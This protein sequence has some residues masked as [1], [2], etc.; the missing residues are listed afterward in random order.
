MSVF[1]LFFLALR[2]AW[3]RPRSR[4]LL[5][6]RTSPLQALSLQQRLRRRRM[7][8]DDVT[9]SL[10]R[11][12][13]RRRRLKASMFDSKQER[14]IEP[15]RA[16]IVRFRTY[17]RHRHTCARLRTIWKSTT[18][19]IAPSSLSFRKMTVVSQRSIWTRST[20]KTFQTNIRRRQQVWIRKTGKR[21]NLSPAYFV[22]IHPF[23]DRVTVVGICVNGAPI[24]QLLGRARI[25]A[26]SAK[27]SSKAL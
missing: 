24:T 20:T 8:I 23:F 12:C 14:T 4:S 21:A 17:L 19:W 15:A 2:R 13:R 22:I 11:L 9:P 10:Q 18:L 26:S 25:S 5:L 1:L 7:Q 16:P 27:A 6:R 3:S